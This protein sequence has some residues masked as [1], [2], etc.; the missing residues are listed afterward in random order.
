MTKRQNVQYNQEA[1]DYLINYYNEKNMT[2]IRKEIK[3]LTGVMPSSNAVRIKASRLGLECMQVGGGHILIKD[4]NEALHTM[5]GNKF[6]KRG[7]FTKKIPGLNGSVVDVKK[8]WE[9]V[10]T[11]EYIDLTKYERGTLL[12]EPKPDRKTG[13]SWLDVRI[14]QQLERKRLEPT[15]DEDTIKKLS[16][17][18]E[19]GKYSRNEIAEHFNISLNQLQY[20]ITLYDLKRR[21]HIKIT[22][23]ER[24]EIKELYKNGATIR[25]IEKAYSRTRKTVLRIIGKS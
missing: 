13:K 14:E 9:Y 18:L 16:D 2:T 6:A 8:F 17:M 21:V 25:E 24:K 3:R 19:S 20:R 22:D 23:K 5:Q 11:N 1:I 15:W 12:P 10:K 4:I 7:K